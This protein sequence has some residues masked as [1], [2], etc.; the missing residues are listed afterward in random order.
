MSGGAVGFSADGCAPGDGATREGRNGRLSRSSAAGRE[1]FVPM[2]A[3]AEVMGVEVGRLV[4]LC[5]AVGPARRPVFLRG[6]MLRGN[7]GWMVPAR[8]LGLVTVLPGWP[9][10]SVR[11]AAELLGIDRSVAER[12]PMV[13]LVPGFRRVALGSVLSGKAKREEAA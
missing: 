5:G 9:F 12:L 4:A 13:E 6:A 3:L 2:E 1:D 8:V 7:D 10:V 11:A